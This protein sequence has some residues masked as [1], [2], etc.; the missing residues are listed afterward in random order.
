MSR[1]LQW[2]SQEKY[3]SNNSNILPNKENNVYHSSQL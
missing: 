3:A 1:E 2:F